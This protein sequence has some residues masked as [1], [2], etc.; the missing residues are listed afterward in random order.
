MQRQEDL[1]AALQRTDVLHVQSASQHAAD[2]RKSG[3]EAEAEAAAPQTGQQAAAVVPGKTH[4]K[5]VVQYSRR[6]VPTS[7]QKEQA[8]QSQ[9]LLDM[10]EYFAE[11]WFTTATA[12]LKLFSGDPLTLQLHPLSACSQ[13]LVP[14]CTGTLAREFRVC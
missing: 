11:V 3:T 1:A 12:G 9:H 13:M 14:C 4:K 5:D 8:A 7:K 6:P 10:K 2:I